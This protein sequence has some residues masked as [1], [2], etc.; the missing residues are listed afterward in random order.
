MGKAK[1]P[2]KCRNK[3]TETDRGQS[4]YYLGNSW[5]A[6]DVH[7]QSESRPTFDFEAFLIRVKRNVGFVK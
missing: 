3:K 4:R 6:N 7:N 5:S 2:E 1:Q